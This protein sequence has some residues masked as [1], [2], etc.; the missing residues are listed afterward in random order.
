[1]S[2]IHHFFAQIT[3]RLNPDEAR[4]ALRQTAGFMARV[5]RG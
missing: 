1:M 2:K 3:R 4:D 5:L